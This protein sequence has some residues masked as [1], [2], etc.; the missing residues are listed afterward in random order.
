MAATDYSLLSIDITVF[1]DVERNPAPISSEEG[2][3]LR[4]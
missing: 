3:D 2:Y 1:M 4:K